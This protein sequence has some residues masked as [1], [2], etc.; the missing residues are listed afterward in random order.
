ML[1]MD[2]QSFIEY[3]CAIKMQMNQLKRSFRERELIT[4]VVGQ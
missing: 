4:H 2:I 1:I 3:Y